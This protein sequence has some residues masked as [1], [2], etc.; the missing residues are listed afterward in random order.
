MQI[1][2]DQ[3]ISVTQLKLE[4]I[5]P[6]KLHQ[7]NRTGKS[8]TM[9]VCHNLRHDT[10]IITKDVTLECGPRDSLHH[11]VGIPSEYV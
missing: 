9:K 10:A 11:N 5:R 1:K 8:Y 7:L 2:T 4:V 3:R 6:L